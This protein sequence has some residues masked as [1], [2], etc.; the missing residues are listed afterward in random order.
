MIAGVVIVVLVLVAVVMITVIA[1]AWL[2]RLW[3]SFLHNRTVEWI[4]RRATIARQA[5]SY[6]EAL[7]LAPSR[8]TALTFRVQRKAVAL[9]AISGELDSKERFR[10]EQTTRRYLPDTLN[11]FQM[12]VMGGD[13]ERRRVAQDLLVDQLAQLEDN[14]DRIAVDAGDRG[15]DVLMAN[16]LFIRSISAPP[17]DD[18]DLPKPDS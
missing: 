8:A 4:A 11:A 18:L 6:R 3:A 17:A 10:V 9:E 2:R 16:G 1:I 12:A 15:I 13:A 5:L 14:L 7:S